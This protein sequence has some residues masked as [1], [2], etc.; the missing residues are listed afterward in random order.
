MYLHL[1]LCL[2]LFLKMSE[3]ILAKLPATY[4]GPF[5]QVNPYIYIY[6]HTDGL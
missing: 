6:I 4:L 3:R 1:Y 5:L 2:C